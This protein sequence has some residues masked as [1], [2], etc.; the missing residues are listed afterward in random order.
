[1]VPE[2]FRVVERDPDGKVVSHSGWN[3]TF[4]TTPA[5]SRQ[6]A[7]AVAESERHLFPN[8]KDFIY[9]ESIGDVPFVSD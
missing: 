2:G 4:P 7:E 1:M 8:R 9:V 6:K 5:M 3:G